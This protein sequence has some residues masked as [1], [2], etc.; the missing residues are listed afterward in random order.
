MVA[1]INTVTPPLFSTPYITAQEWRD[2]PTQINADNL[3]ANNADAS[4]AMLSTLIANACSWIDTFCGQILA[5]TLDTEKTKTR[6]DRNGI[7][8]IHPRYTPICSVTA[9]SYGSDQSS[10]AALS[11]LSNIWVEP[12]KFEVP[13]TFAPFYSSVG[14]LQFGT[15]I[16]GQEMYV[17]YSYV[18]G[19]VVTTLAATAVAG[20]SSIVVA[21]STGILPG[22]TQLGIYDGGKTESVQVASSYDGASTTVPIVGTLAHDHGQVGVSV[23]S[24]PPGVKQAAIMLTTALVKTRGTTAIQAPTVK[25][26][27]SRAAP[28][29]GGDHDD[30]IALAYDLLDNYRR[31]R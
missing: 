27:M 19:Y 17:Q 31:V 24:L 4:A 15:P 18:S 23:S 21:S 26:N 2:Y 20:A 14:P 10:L 9:F 7:L 22:V 30:D 11:S 6:V 13:L 1:P 16:A 25:G 5:A 12:A 28:K 8:H 29:G 3:V